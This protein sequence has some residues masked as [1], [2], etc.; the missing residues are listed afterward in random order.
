[1]SESVS[2]V[3]VDSS[4]KKRVNV[5]LDCD[6]YYLAQSRYG[7]GNVSNRINE[8][9]SIDLHQSSEKEQLIEKLHELR[10]EERAITDKICQLNKM[11]REKEAEESSIDKVLMWVRD[12]YER[13]GVVGLN[14]VEMEC[15]RLKVNY[16]DV[17][18]ILEA[19]EI[20]TVN[21]Q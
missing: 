18:K 10:I 12:L 4:N 5:N 15:K 7:K 19:E 11:E 14:Q 8:L 2:G 3:K 20:A 17:L 13:K 21:Y 9:L 1:M 6:L 16:Y